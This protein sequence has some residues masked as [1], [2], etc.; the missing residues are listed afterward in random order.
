MRVLD[1]CAESRPSNL[2]RLQPNIRH[3]QRNQS[4]GLL[5]AERSIHCRA[6]PIPRRDCHQQTDHTSP[7]LAQ[8]R[9]ASTGSFRRVAATVLVSAIHHLTPAR[10]T[11]LHNP[12]LPNTVTSHR[13]VETNP[14]TTDSTR[15]ERKGEYRENVGS[16]V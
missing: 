6:L 8:L 10:H 3:E 2:V 13:R 16:C 11:P 4:V 7:P 12:P 9:H 1:V 5:A 15:T 14:S